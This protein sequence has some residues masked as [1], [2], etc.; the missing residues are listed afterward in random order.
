MATVVE[1]CLVT[2]EIDFVFKSLNELMNALLHLQ[3]KMKHAMTIS[4]SILEMGIII[5]YKDNHGFLTK[6]N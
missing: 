3:Q 2:I 6:K 5:I 1:N 4:L